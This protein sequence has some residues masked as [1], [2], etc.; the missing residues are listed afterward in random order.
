MG[1]YIYMENRNMKKV[2]RLTESDLMRLVKRV[3]NEG[4][5]KIKGIMQREMGFKF[6]GSEVRKDETNGK[7][8]EVS[9]YDKILKYFKAIVTII[10]FPDVENGDFIFNIKLQFKNGSEKDMTEIGRAHV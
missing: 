3:I 9:R 8:M 5:E 10:E 6:L 4:D 1:G 7:S 2:I